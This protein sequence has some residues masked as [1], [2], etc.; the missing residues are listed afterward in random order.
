MNAEQD[1]LAAKFE[2]RALEVQFMSGLDD[3][4]N[5]LCA[6]AA[7]LEESPKTKSPKVRAKHSS[8][9]REVVVE[10]ACLESAEHTARIAQ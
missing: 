9:H 10:Q 1:S 3:E 5:V 6:Y 7:E 2:K 8:A 4:A